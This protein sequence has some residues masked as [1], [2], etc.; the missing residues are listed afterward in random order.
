MTFDQIKVSIYSLVGML[1]VDIIEL[2]GMQ[3]LLII[4]V[5]IKVQKSSSPNLLT[6]R[7]NSIKIK[8][9]LDNILIAF[10][11]ISVTNGS[12][13]LISEDVLKIRT[14]TSFHVP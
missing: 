1:I 3:N 8:I 6:V 4:L 14:I 5:V 13:L 7:I 2:T 11:I 12:Y 9:F 10:A